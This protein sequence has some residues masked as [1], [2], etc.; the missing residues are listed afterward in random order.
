VDVGGRRAG[1][2]AAAACADPGGGTRD[3]RP[4]GLAA[5]LTGLRVGPT[6][7]S[8]TCCGCR[9]GK[10]PAGRVEPRR[11]AGALVLWRRRHHARARAC[12]YQRQAATGRASPPRLHHPAPYVAP[13]TLKPLLTKTWRWPWW[14]WCGPPAWWP[15]R[16]RP[17]RR[18]PRAD[19][20]RCRGCC[21]SPSPWTRRLPRPWELAGSLLGT[22]Q[23]RRTGQLVAG[24]GSAW[25]P[26]PPVARGS[27]TR[28]LAPR[29]LRP[30][31]AV[32]GS[33]Y[34]G[35]RRLTS[36]LCWV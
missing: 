29:L 15:R 16:R 35:I 8:A 19:L 25:T 28:N 33:I 12:H 27:T 34:P 1:R 21:L 23:R 13:V 7:R 31:R 3:P 11:R 20:P 14:W 24:V 26:G 30:G 2:S 4:V 32:T 10:T 22:H 9:C 18:R 36:A 5:H 6:S 17:C